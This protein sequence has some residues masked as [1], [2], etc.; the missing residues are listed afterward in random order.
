MA[1]E[2]K[3]PANVLFA[4]LLLSAGSLTIGDVRLTPFD[5]VPVPPELAEK[6]DTDVNPVK[7][8]KEEEP[9]KALAAKLRA[10]DEAKK[11]PPKS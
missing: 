6:V 8:F 4:V 5:V 3:V 10:E 1:G 7:F 9:A 2:K 11:K